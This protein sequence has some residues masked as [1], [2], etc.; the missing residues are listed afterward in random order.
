MC[1]LSSD[2]ACLRRFGASPESQKRSRKRSKIQNSKR[3]SAWLRQY[4]YVCT[5][6]AS[7]LINTELEKVEWVAGDLNDK[8]TIAPTMTGVKK[9]I[10]AAGAHGWE[11]I[12]N[13]RRIYAEAV[14]EI[15]RVSLSE[16]SSR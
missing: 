4:L 14:G 13:N 2:W 1:N 15:A 12:E 9:V 16:S 8:S 3:W 7:K 11:D 6:K 5:S 10:F